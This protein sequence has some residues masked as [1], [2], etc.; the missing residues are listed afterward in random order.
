MHSRTAS[1][2]LV[3]G[4]EQYRESDYEQDYRREGEA[5]AEEANEQAGEEDGCPA[6]EGDEEVYIDVGN[7]SWQQLGS[8][9]N[10]VKNHER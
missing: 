10:K 5:Q 8:L 7:F 2:Y 9:D 3:E 6:S 1:W 4:E